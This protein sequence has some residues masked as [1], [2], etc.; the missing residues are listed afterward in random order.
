MAQYSE[1]SARPAV[2]AEN[3][4]RNRVEL[5]D[6]QPNRALLLARILH[7]V[8]GSRPNGHVRKAKTLTQAPGTAGG[9]GRSPTGDLILRFARRAGGN[10]AP[11]SRI[12]SISFLK[13]LC[14]S[15]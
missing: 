6:S 1:A 13:Q 14:G 7:L 5:R 4:Y 2:I 11:I 10:I 8:S 9:A 3:V 15:A 12:R